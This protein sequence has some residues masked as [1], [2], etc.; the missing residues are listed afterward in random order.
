M[1]DDLVHVMCQTRPPPR[2]QP[3]HHTAVHSSLLGLLRWRC[4]AQRAAV[5]RLAQPAV[6][7]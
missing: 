7:L 6:A 5:A 2:R 3:G 4:G 1:P